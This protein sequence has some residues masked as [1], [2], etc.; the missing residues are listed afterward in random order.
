MLSERLSKWL[1]PCLQEAWCKASDPEVPQAWRDA[2]LVLLAKR[3]VRC[4]KDVR[5]IALTDSI[6]KT[7]LG[8]LTTALKH[9]FYPKLQ[10]L[11]IF[12]FVP[13]RGT[14][15]A[16][17]FV[18]QHCRL[19]RS[20]CEA[21]SQSFWKRAAGQP[22]LAGG[23]MLSLDMSQAFDRLPRHHLAAGLQLLE[24]DPAL[25][26]FFL[27]WLDQATYHFQHRRSPCSVTTTQ[28]V[29]Q[30][31]KASPLEW[32]IFLVLLLTRLDT[33]LTAADQSSW[34]KEHLITYADDLLAHWCVQSRTQVNNAV[35]NMGKVLDVLEAFGMIVN[36][37]KSVVLLRLSGRQAK[38]IKKKLL[39]KTSQGLCIRVPRS[40]GTFTMLPVVSQ[41]VYLGIQISYH[42][43]EDQTVTHRLKIGRTTFLRLRAWLV[44]RHTFP[45]HL[46]LALW[47]ACV[48]S[49]SIYGLQ[50]TG[51]T[52]AGALKLHRQFAG[53]LRKIARSPNYISRETTADL[54]TR[55]GVPLPLHRLQAF[56]S[57]QYERQLQRW[58]G[59][60]LDDFMRSFDLES[61]HA[62]IAQTF[63]QTETPSFVDVLLC[64][65]CDFSTMQQSQLT[66][67]LRKVH[68]VAAVCNQFCPLRD[69]LAGYPQCAH[70]SRRLASRAGLKRHIIQNHCLYFDQTRPLQAALADDP[71]L[72]AMAQCRDWTP[73]WQDSALLKRIREQ[74][75]LCGLQYASR[76]SM[77]DHLHNDHQQA[78]EFAQ[79]FVATIASQ[80]ASD[81][82]QACGHTGK[83][84]HK[85][86]VVRQL[87]CITALQSQDYST[88]E[89]EDS[90]PPEAAPLTS[91]LKRAR[92]QDPGSSG[93]SQVSFQPARDACGGEPICAHCGTKPST[94][95]ILRRHIEDGYCKMFNEERP[96]GGH[97]PGTW[98]NLLQ[99]AHEA[100]VELLKEP[101][102]ITTLNGV[103]ALCGQQLKRPGAIM[104]HLQRDHAATLSE[105]QQTNPEL[106]AKLQNEALCHCA[107]H[108]HKRDH[109]CPVHYQILLLHHLGGRRQAQ[110]QPTESDFVELWEDPQIRARLTHACAICHAACDVHE[111]SIHLQSHAEVIHNVSHLF[112]LAQSPFMDCCAACLQAP[113]LLPCCPVAQESWG[114][115]LPNSQKRLKRP[116]PQQAPH[117]AAHQPSAETQHPTSKALLALVLRHETAGPGHGRSRSLSSHHSVEGFTAERPDLQTIA[118]SPVS[119][120]GPRT[121]DQAG[122]GDGSQTT[123]RSVDRDPLGPTDHTTGSLELHAVLPQAEEA[124]S[125][126]LQDPYWHGQDETMDPGTPG[127]CPGPSSGVAVQGLE[128]T[129]HLSYSGGNSTVAA[130]DHREE[131]QTMGDSECGQ[132]LGSLDASLLPLET[133]PITIQPFGG[134]LGTQLTRPIQGD[135][136]SGACLKLRLLN[137]GVICY[138]NATLLAFLWGMM[139]REDPTW[140]DFAFG[141]QG[142][143]A[144]LTDG[145][146]GSFAFESRGF[147]GLAHVW[148]PR[149]GQEDAH[150]FVTALLEWSRPSCANMSWSRR[151]SEAET[152]TMYDTG[153]RGMPPTLTI[154]ACEKG[155]C[156]MQ[157]L[158][159]TWHEHSGMKTCFH[160][161]ADLLCLHLD[162]HTRNDSGDVCRAAWE[163][164]VD[165]NVLI[166]I[167]ND[168]AG[169]TLHCRE[170][171]P[172][173]LVLH[174]GTMH[175]GHLQAALQTPH[176]WVITD[177]GRVALEDPAQLHGNLQNITYIW[178]VRDD[179]LRFHEIPPSLVG[180]DA[181]VTKTTWY[182]FHGKF[183]AL[184]EDKETISLLRQFCAD[185]GAPF[186][187]PQSFYDHVQ[188]KHPGFGVVLHQEYRRIIAQLHTSDIPCD[189]CLATWFPKGQCNL[190]DRFHVCP[191]VMNMAVAWMYHGSTLAEIGTC[192]NLPSADT[193][194][195]LVGLPAPR[196]A[197]E[198][199]ADHFSA[200]LD[201]LTRWWCCWH[202]D[203]GRWAAATFMPPPWRCLSPA[204][205]PRFCIKDLT[206]NS[207]SPWASN[208]ID[209]RLFS[210]S[211]WKPAGSREQSP[212]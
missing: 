92:Q 60:S 202:L 201:A 33:E 120:F 45:L 211:L 99:R 20:S 64:P 34:I 61:H 198:D 77:L 15:E 69:A 3:A 100:P 111:L 168:P 146:F 137:D 118:H 79:P 180:K 141:E 189:L 18:C 44:K 103:C 143:N 49:A 169:I 200:F 165:P 110:P 134:D 158:I 59:L 101:G 206:V 142:F 1:W 52:S 135:Q 117:Q 65:Y 183:S 95:Y 78:W 178:L 167:W 144:L 164:S 72:R 5:P 82:C 177:D 93:T 179:I 124:D 25:S 172:I 182:L 54:C 166:P 85:C 55:L 83:R 22:L 80:V 76:K 12:A 207:C 109:R 73:L 114:T 16:L 138:Q 123:G 171:V 70:C 28:G 75:A 155:A 104:P 113:A 126:V 98:P 13:N 58:Q 131:Q 160:E 152:I 84:A 2:W 184:K 161:A 175:S 132:P 133:P 89:I 140:S 14:L 36:L 194:A 94:M 119:E 199:A 190:D 53:D 66:M 32:T 187:G 129:E 205:S 193:P 29:R 41:H 88:V 210:F 71:A 106:L 4:A 10:H 37:S 63:T 176:G 9:Q 191:T 39:I 57:Q 31:C 67:H 186:F 128:T 96:I 115:L 30:G 11:P 181:W 139:Q 203:P 116:S 212:S 147:E 150:E 163:I 208:Q 108:Y 68:C 47:S 127:T 121:V 86:P 157:Q 105:A 46:R 162:R 159:D 197:N 38:T 125:Y 209:V 192:F 151:M 174:S 19:V 35:T 21:N 170:Y 43:F 74:C 173:S 196:A 97:I 26:Q 145:L 8:L 148:G 56:W 188:A 90:A 204:E 112:P 122:K 149:A 102:T 42:N 27:K 6:G 62:M 7:I 24:I 156:S 23:M 51:L 50:A 40:N 81:P 195:E 107:S 91:P 17:Y 136:A 153:S 185:C 48:R 87:A 154:G 130:S